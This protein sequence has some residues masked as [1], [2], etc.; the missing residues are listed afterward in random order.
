MIDGAHVRWQ[1]LPSSQ[2][3]RTCRA[4]QGL[5]QCDL[6]PV[7][8]SSTNDWKAH[9]VGLSRKKAGSHLNS[10]KFGGT[11]KNPPLPYHVKAYA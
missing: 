11:E 1:G 5:L 7:Q 2:Q 8:I 9:P 4:G 3:I 10:C 6:R